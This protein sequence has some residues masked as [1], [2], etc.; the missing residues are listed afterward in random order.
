MTPTAT[1]QFDV[2]HAR[3][4]DSL[5]EPV[6]VIDRGMQIVYLNAAARSRYDIP[7]LSAAPCYCFKTT[8]G[9]DTP[10]S[11]DGLS[12]PVRAVFETGRA[13]RAIHY[14]RSHDGVLLPEE[15]CAAPLRSSSGEVDH[16]IETVRNA[17]ELLE[18]REV[19]EHM[20]SELDLLRGI[21]STC[22]E[23]RRIR[24]PDGNWEEMEVYV[25]R[26]SAAQFSHGICPTCAAKL[27][28]TYEVSKR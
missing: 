25:S 15:V 11:S 13:S 5:V 28:P 4:L 22:A 23:C 21:L 20:R 16:V 10:C 24:T 14:H 27:Y 8:H 2:D 1:S 17:S 7:S 6:L 12:C 3:I 18:T 19:I 26:H 9:R